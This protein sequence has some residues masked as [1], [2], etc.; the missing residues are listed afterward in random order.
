MAIDLA[1]SCHS[2]RRDDLLSPSAMGEIALPHA[3]AA[4]R[5]CD[6]G[7]QRAV[8]GFAAASAVAGAAAGAPTGRDA[9]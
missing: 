3:Q 4:L 9:T 8:T 7:R 2:E 1:G 5:F 6:S